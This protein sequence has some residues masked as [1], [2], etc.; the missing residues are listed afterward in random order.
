MLVNDLQSRI[1]DLELDLVPEEVKEQFF[2]FV[3]NVPFIQALISPDRKYAKDL[4]RDE[5]GKIIVDITKP[6]ILEDMDYFR[7]AAINFQK[8]GAY[9][10]ARPDGNPNSK[11]GKWVREEVRRCY[12]GMVRPSDGEWITGDYYFFLNYCPMLLVEQ[13]GAK[14]GKRKLGFPRVWEGHYYLF[15]YLDQA[16]KAGQHAF[17]LASRAKGKSF[18]GASML[19]KRFELGESEDVQQKVICYITASDKKYLDGGDQTLNKFVFDIDHCAVNT[20]FPSRRL[21]N[22]LNDMQW[23]SG[24]KDLDSGTNKGSQNAVIGV[25]S[26]K[27]ASKLRGTRG[28]LYILEEAGTFQKLLDTY[29]NL[30]HS[31][32]QGGIAYGLI[33]GYGT[34]GDTE[35]DFSAMQEIMYSPDG[36]NVYGVPN[37]Y[38]VEGQAADK[39]VF[40]FPGYL[41]L[42]GFYDSNGNSNVLGALKW[43]LMDR[44]KVKYG[45]INVN[46]IIK[47]IAE[48]PI[49]PQEAILRTRSNFFPTVQINERINQLDA[50]PTLYNEVYTGTFVMDS[51]GKVNFQPTNDIPIRNFPLKED[52]PNEGCVEIY[53]MPEK[54]TNGEVYSN[55]YIAGFDPYD[56]DQAESKSLGSFFVLD[57]WTDKLVMEYTGRTMYAEQLYE[58]VRLGCMFYNA[59]VLYESN[60]K[61]T[62]AYFSKMNCLH[63]LADTPEYLRDKQLIKYSSFGSNSKGV[64][65]SGPINR[66]ADER[67]KDWMLKP[68]TTVIIED[69]E[70][71]EITVP[72]LYF[73]MCRA[74]LKEAAQYNDKGNFD[75]I[76]ALGMLML[77]REDKM[78]LYGGD[79]KNSQVEDGDDLA[80]DDFFTRNYD[81]RFGN[82]QSDFDD[83]TV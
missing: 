35:S 70:E 16:R 39:F 36:Y 23:V 29:N 63:L 19:A 2:D 9:T 56:N 8:N 44:Y 73:M 82:F 37:V 4:P 72:N 30:R 7:Q 67:L 1:E 53:Q 22:S 80:E 50:D 51:R 46:A 41:N 34:A 57:M 28:V 62:F 33:F 25:S 79:I 65:A 3:N 38:D 69:G 77:Y 11:Y 58:L 45:S 59:T 68:V 12:Y 55:R 32:E 14:V 81:Q 48:S 54:D 71:K 21:T 40:F 15:H 66:Y 76:R 75:R 18:G 10:D 13:T 83:F 26:S 17:M 64:N 42:E 74:A 5:E 60:K 24:Y 52:D 20:Q 43:I 31:V 6:H 27:D 47:R 78:I 61:G 49:V